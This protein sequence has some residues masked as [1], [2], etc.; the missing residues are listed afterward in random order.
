MKSIAIF[1]LFLGLI[2]II[3]G[4][5]SKKYKTL[6]EPKVIIKYIPRSEYEEQ[7]SD[8]EK[9]SEFYKNMF[10]LTQPNL[11]DANNINKK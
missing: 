11:Y 8:S 10:E 6:T 9:L 1:I 4:Y 7:L 3:K 5:Y 2:L